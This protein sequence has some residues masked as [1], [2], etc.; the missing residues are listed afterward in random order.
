MYSAKPPNSATRH[1]QT[2]A[3]VQTYYSNWVS[4][5][6]TYV[7]FIFLRIITHGFDFSDV[8]SKF[9]RQEQSKCLNSLVFFFQ[10]INVFLKSFGHQDLHY[11]TNTVFSI[12][13]LVNDLETPNNVL[14]V[15][16]PIATPSNSSHIP[17]SSFL[18]IYFYGFGN[19]VN[20]VMDIWS[21]SGAWPFYKG[22]YA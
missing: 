3:K 12:S 15:S 22:T 14:Y 13:I 4:N 18:K 8:S 10:S 19:S 1:G 11:Y 5:W 21:F 2:P 20:T 6:L 17:T 7:I 9:H 16:V